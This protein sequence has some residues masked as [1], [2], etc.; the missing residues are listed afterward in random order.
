M[1]CPYNLL[2][3][4]IEDLK[5]QQDTSCVVWALELRRTENGRDVVANVSSV[6]SGEEAEW[7]EGALMLIVSTAELTQMIV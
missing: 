1:F 4:W 6:E 5:R 2:K 7:R 3:I